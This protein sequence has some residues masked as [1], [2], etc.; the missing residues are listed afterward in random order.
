MAYENKLNM[1][2]MKTASDKV[3][4]ANSTKGGIAAR[5]DYSVKQN[6]VK[7]DDFGS[8]LSKATAKV[9]AVDNSFGKDSIS[10]QDNQQM[11]KKTATEPEI[12][13]KV[14]SATT[15]VT[16]MDN[17]VDN[18]TDQDTETTVQGEL[19]EAEADLHP[20]NVESD[21]MAA[22]FQFMSH[23]NSI[24]ALLNDK[25]ILPMAQET[26]VKPVAEAMVQGTNTVVQSTESGVNIK[27][28]T[29]VTD[30][31]VNQVMTD[32]TSV[33]E[34]ETVQSVEGASGAIDIPEGFQQVKPQQV[35]PASVEALLGSKS[36]VANGQDMLNMLSGRF[37]SQPTTV[38][39]AAAEN[40]VMP[41]AVLEGTT[42]NT[43][44]SDL[45][46][47]V[48]TNIVTNMQNEEMVATY[49]V[50]NDDV[51]NIIG[52]TVEAVVSET[53][54]Q[55]ISSTNT[56]MVSKTVDN[57]IEML[58][59]LVGKVQVA[60]EPVKTVMED[61]VAGTVV[62]PAINNS[63]VATAMEVDTKT[64]IP[65]SDIQEAKVAISSDDIDVQLADSK[66]AN[67]SARAENP[68]VETQAAT[69]NPK[70]EAVEKVQ[71]PVTRVNDVVEGPAV[72]FIPKTQ[73]TADSNQQSLHQ[74]FAEQGAQQPQPVNADGKVQ[75]MQLA[76][77]A[78]FDVAPIETTADTATSMAVGASVQQPAMVDNADSL[79]QVQQPQQ[80]TTDYEIPKQIVEQARLIRAGQDT[81][82]V[83][84][85]NPRHLGE[86]TLKVAV[87][88]GG[89]VTATFHSDN[90][91]VRGII[92]TSMMQLKQELTE[93]GIKVDKIEISAGLQQD[94]QD[95]GQ[96]YYAQQGGQQRTAT[97]NDLNNYENGEG[98]EGEAGEGAASVDGV[99]VNNSTEPIR[100]SQGNVISDGVDYSV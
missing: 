26:V 36:S 24:D 78:A 80:S 85:L 56:Q 91:T 2:F 88:A 55:E 10:Q 77:E 76:G 45:M 53:I 8:Q 13:D 19:V 22:L 59:N 20:E 84:K 44:S 74:Q 21:D 100:D 33:A 6:N 1:F 68:V 83:I 39:Q 82:M 98:V 48:V 50:L 81:E 49:P 5:G 71:T 89:S 66:A 58:N 9:E 99:P 96:G 7:A 72:Q 41:Q 3:S 70:Q 37:V 64:A 35:Q 90:A 32:F 16:T 65:V 47:E 11:M 95:M 40:L 28:L 52:K 23:S 15:D 92:E 18:V 86:L 4:V 60:S 57:G 61:T 69:I 27:P 17:T 63:E 43:V 73:E 67:A 87:H 46:G 97:R 42:A 54:E 38:Q 62:S 12:K 30:E 29:Q 51:Q 79:Q 31:A 34:V 25:Q 93:Q 94:L 14:Q 75:P